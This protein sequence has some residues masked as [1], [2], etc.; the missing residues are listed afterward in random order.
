MIRKLCAEDLNEVVSIWYA[1]SVKAHDFISEEFWFKQKTPMRDVYLPS[2]E[3]WVY[4]AD[5]QIL[6]FVSYYQGF[7]P[8]LFVSPNAQSKGLGRE[9]LSILKESYSQ[10]NLAVYAENSR[11]HSFYMRQGFKEVERKPC[12]HTG[13]EEIIMVWVSAT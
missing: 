6:G 4:E 5:K 8:A 10:L 7:I 1:S 13:H 12:E 9:L 11:A 2:S 3:T